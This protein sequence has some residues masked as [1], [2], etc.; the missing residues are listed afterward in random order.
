LTVDIIKLKET[1]DKITKDGWIDN[2][3]GDPWNG[4]EF[5][6]VFNSLKEYYNYRLLANKNALRE[7]EKK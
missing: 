4:E 2:D 1:I 3:Q 7:G 6:I 5:D